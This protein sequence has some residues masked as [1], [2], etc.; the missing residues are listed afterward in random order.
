ME[1]YTVKTQLRPDFH[2]LSPIF[3]PRELAL[4]ATFLPFQQA[5]L[6]HLRNIREYCHLFGPTKYI[7]YLRSPAKERSTSLANCLKRVG[8]S[9]EIANIVS[10]PIRQLLPPPALRRHAFLN[11]TIHVNGQTYLSAP[12][13]VALMLGSIPVTLLPKDPLIVEIGS[14]S[15]FHLLCT[16]ATVPHSR[17]VGLDL[18]ADAC[19]IAQGLLH[20]RLGTRLLR[21]QRGD[22]LHSS[23]LP[24]ADYLYSTAACSLGQL[25]ILQAQMRPGSFWT[26]P[27][28]LTESE[29]RSEP[30]GSWLRARYGSYAN[31]L[32]DEWWN[33]VALETAKILTPTNREQVSVLYDLQFVR[34]SK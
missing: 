34:L 12:T 23:W 4:R 19:V 2:E 27:R 28:Q 33:F 22:A 5:T 16:A 1:S 24:D 25:Q 18:S 9:P 15:G 32:T 6:L 30:A 26:V 8:F 20:K 31:Y 13:L 10:S 17:L 7:R 3:G 29:F 11:S 21:L 14:G